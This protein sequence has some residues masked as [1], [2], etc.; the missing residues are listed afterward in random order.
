MATPNTNTSCVVSFESYARIRT[1]PVCTWGGDYSA[2]LSG[3]AFGATET[4]CRPKRTHPTSRQTLEPCAALRRCV[5]TCKKTN[6]TKQPAQHHR[7]TEIAAQLKPYL[8]QTRCPNTDPLCLPH[9]IRHSK[10]QSHLPL[11]AVAPRLK[12][13][14]KLSVVRSR[15]GVGWWLSKL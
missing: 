9:S 13:H 4:S 11:Q 3:Q 12:R 7:Q 5:T 15:S 6:P 10:C 2:K 14:I 1:C 8:Y